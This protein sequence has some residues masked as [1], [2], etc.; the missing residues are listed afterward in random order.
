MSTFIIEPLY[1]LAFACGGWCIAGIVVLVGAAYAVGRAH[2]K[3]L[4]RQEDPDSDAETLQPNN[5]GN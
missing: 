5:P 1:I 4:D 2:Q 3:S